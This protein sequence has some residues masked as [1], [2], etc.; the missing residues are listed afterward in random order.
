[1]DYVLQEWSL[2]SEYVMLAFQ[3]VFMCESCH[4]VFTHEF[5]IKALVLLYDLDMC[6]YTVNTTGIQAEDNGFSPFD[7][8]T[9]VCVWSLS[10]SYHIWIQNS[11]SGVCDPLNVSVYSI[12]WTH[13]EFMMRWLF[14]VWPFNLCLRVK[15]VSHLSNWNLEFRLWS[16]LRN[17][18]P[19]SVCDIE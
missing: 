8:S 6:L 11:G 9:C 3:L 14:Y 1:M 10:H 16:F 15:F 19:V 7:L 18:L 2:N 17:Y 4:A 5:R 13:L 12:Q